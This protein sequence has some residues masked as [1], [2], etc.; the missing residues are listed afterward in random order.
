MK[1]PKLWGLPREDNQQ[2][3]LC[4]YVKFSSFGSF[5]RSCQTTISPCLFYKVSNAINVNFLMRFPHNRRLNLFN[6]WTSHSVQ[7]NRAGPMTKSFLLESQ[8]KVLAIWPLT[9]LEVRPPL[10][11]TLPGCPEYEIPCLC[12]LN[13][14]LLPRNGLCGLNY[15]LPV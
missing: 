6:L 7:A 12:G 8:L 15:S 4:F 2:I 5:L 10:H 11:D 13:G 1:P 3:Q 9:E 14:S